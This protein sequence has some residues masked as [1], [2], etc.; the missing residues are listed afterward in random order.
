MCSIEW[1]FGNKVPMAQEKRPCWSPILELLL[2]CFIKK[3]TSTADIL[4]E[5]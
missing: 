3:R 5:M 1:L 4:R 2:R